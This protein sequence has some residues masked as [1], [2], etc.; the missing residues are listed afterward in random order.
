M[1]T[2]RSWWI[3]IALITFLCGGG[4]ADTKQVRMPGDMRFSEYTRADSME[5]ETSSGALAD[6]S[7]DIP[8]FRGW[9][10]RPYV[11]VGEIHHRDP[12]KEWEEGEIKDAVKGARRVKGD[13]IIIRL[14]SER[15]VGAVTGTVGR[16]ALRGG[17]GI[18]GG[19]TALVIRW[20]TDAEVQA[21]MARDERLR[22]QLL[23]EKPNLG[24][25]NETAALAIKYLLQTGEGEIAPDFFDRYRQIISRLSPAAPAD[26]SGD[27]IFKAVIKEKAL[28]SEKEDQY[29]GIASARAD[30]ANLAIV[31][32][33]GKVEMSF[34]GESAKGRL[35]GQ[36]AV[37]GFSGEAEGVA[38]EDKISI[39]FHNLTPDGV[40]QGVVVLQRNRINKADESK[41]VV[42]SL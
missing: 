12:R 19:I 1:I 15:G 2:K 10:S 3:A 14:T 26:F 9:P 34:S 6:T 32:T 4:L 31:S 42:K 29:L 7:F 28:V 40:A 8:V 5:W 37:A 27:W 23:A 30:G 25:N 39:S 24:I 38:L 13:A 41:S 17:M 22:K 11:V 36:A 16:G 18:Q 33:E 20:Q 21:R 35:K